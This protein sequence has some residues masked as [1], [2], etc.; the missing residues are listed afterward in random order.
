MW[1]TGEYECTNYGVQLDNHNFIK[2]LGVNIDENLTLD[3]SW[4]LPLLYN[5]RNSLTRASLKLLCNSLINPYLI[6]CNVIRGFT[7]EKYLQ[8]LCVLQ[9]KIVRIIS[10]AKRYDHSPPLFK[11]FNFSTEDG[12]NIYMSCIYI[13][14][15][16]QFRREAVC[17][18]SMFFYGTIQGWEIHR[19]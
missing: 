6:Y 11:A 1:T 12:I 16:I 14:K 17:L 13:Y 3:I 9:K 8:L 18:K 2:Y 5:V 15:A 4:L 19:L 10:Y 7:Y